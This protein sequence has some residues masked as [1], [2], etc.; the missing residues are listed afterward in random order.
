WIPRREEAGHE[1]RALARDPSRVAPPVE[2]ARADVYTGEGLARAL[3]EVQVAYYLIHSMEREPPGARARIDKTSP[4]V[5]TPE[6]FEERER[7]AAERFGEA[8]HAAG[9]RRIVFRGGLLPAAA[10]DGEGERNGSSARG[11]AH[12]TS[13]GARI[14]RH[15]HSRAQVERTLLGAVA[16][17]VA[18]RASIVIGARSRSFRLL[19]RLIERMPAIPLPAWRDCRTQPIDARDVIEMLTGAAT[20][21]VGGRSLD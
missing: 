13:D 10:L 18:L 16:D 15:L 17:S 6:R 8:A 9:G 5:P 2:V 4:A 21:D 3:E 7:V 12:C 14:S 19:V 1:V 11:E 20:A